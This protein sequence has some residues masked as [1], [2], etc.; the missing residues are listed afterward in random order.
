[1]HTSV[2]T[3]KKVSNATGLNQIIRIKYEPSRKKMGDTE[4]G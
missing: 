1:M 2:R 4:S 3:G